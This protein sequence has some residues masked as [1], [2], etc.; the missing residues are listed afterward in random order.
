M[1]LTTETGLDGEYVPS[2]LERIR[3]QVADYEASGGVEGDTLEGRPVVILTS[4]RGRAAPLSPPKEA[5]P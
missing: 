1:T 5:R 2:P 3:K 4:A